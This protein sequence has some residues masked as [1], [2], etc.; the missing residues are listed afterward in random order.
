MSDK[1]NTKI[2]YNQMKCSKS[3]IR[4]FDASGTKYVGLRP[5]S[6]DLDESYD[7]VFPRGKGVSGEALVWDGSGNLEWVPSIGAKGDKG[8]VGSKGDQ[9]PDGNTALNLWHENWTIPSEKTDN[10]VTVT[11]ASNGYIYFQAFRPETTGE[12]TNIKFR[13]FTSDNYIGQMHLS[14]IVAGIYT[15]GGDMSGGGATP[16]PW[17]S[18]TSGSS[19]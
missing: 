12:Y 10:I 13:C 11:D 4:F 3:G 5:V 2:N 19:G 7:L 8:D 9:G 15:N 17:Q 6:E 14:K 16:G 18:R 1:L